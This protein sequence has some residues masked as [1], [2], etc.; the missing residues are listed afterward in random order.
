[1][2]EMRFVRKRRLNGEDV[3][4]KDCFDFDILNPHQTFV[5]EFE[6]SPTRE[7]LDALGDSRLTPNLEE[8]Q[9]STVRVKV[10]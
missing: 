2:T 5:Q 3:Q 1:M 7:M 6:D 10:L 4:H 8:K 9:F